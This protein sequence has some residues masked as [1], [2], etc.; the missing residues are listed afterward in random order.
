MPIGNR[1]A[2]GSED[3]LNEEPLKEGTANIEAVEPMSSEMPQTQLQAAQVRPEET[4]EV[5]EEEL[6]A[7]LKE[8]LTL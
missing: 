4:S 3:I 7:L 2:V 8:F 6:E 1:M 5:T